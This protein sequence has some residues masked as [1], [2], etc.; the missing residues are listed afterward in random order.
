MISDAKSFIWNFFG[1][2]VN[3]ADGTVKVFNSAYVITAYKVANRPYNS[4]RRHCQ[5]EKFVTIF[6]MFGKNAG[7]F[8]DSVRPCQHWGNWKRGNGKRETVESDIGQPETDTHYWFQH[9][10]KTH[11]S[12][13][14]KPKT[15]KS[16]LRHQCRYVIQF[17]RIIILITTF[18]SVRVTNK[19]QSVSSLTPHITFLVHA[20]VI[21]LLVLGIERATQHTWLDCFFGFVSLAV[22]RL[23]KFLFPHFQCRVFYC[24]ATSASPQ[25][26][27][28]HLYM[29]LQKLI[30]TVKLCTAC[31][32]TVN[33]ASGLAEI[34]GEVAGP[35]KT[36]KMP[37]QQ[38]RC[39]SAL[40]FGLTPLWCFSTQNLHSFT[41][42]CIKHE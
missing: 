22:Q 3:E 11:T 27:T 39:F 25:H 33:G 1:N 16:A 20:V 7:N 8:Q 5:H 28:L 18:H 29:S 34:T 12:G 17:K 9:L 13:P 41:R 40:S 38:L 32:F 26:S 30:T 37:V 36:R 10:T 19:P 21:Q 6:W 2:F 23:P 24:R 35:C 42:T 14:S 4:V 15:I 31:I